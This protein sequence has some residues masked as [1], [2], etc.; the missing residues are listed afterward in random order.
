V[1]VVVLCM[2]VVVEQEVLELVLWVCFGLL[3]TRSQLVQVDRQQHQE[4]QMVP[5]GVIVYLHQLHR[6]VV[7]EQDLNTNRLTQAVQ[8]EVVQPRVQVDLELCHKVIMVELVV[9][10]VRHMLVVVEV[11][12]V[13]LVEVI[14]LV[15]EVMVEMGLYLTFQALQY[16]MLAAVAVVYMVD[17]VVSPIAEQVV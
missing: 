5:M 14:L 10:L 1:V 16:I 11:A 2:L 15:Q 8:V 7:A 3:H 12:L 9:L 4:L 17:L 6:Q 13:L